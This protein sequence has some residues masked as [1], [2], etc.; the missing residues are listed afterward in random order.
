MLPTRRQFGTATAAAFALGSPGMLSAAASAPLYFD[1]HIDT[2]S[3]MVS[4][5]LNLAE[6]YP[7]T[8][9]DI[10]KMKQGGLNAGFF[11]V[12]A[13]ARN[14]TPL[15]SVKQGLRIIDVIVE[16]VK[17]HPKDLLLAT[18]SN[19]V[20]RSRREGKI[21]ILLGVEGGHMIDSS[22]EVL[23][24]FYRLG[25]RYLGLT[26][27]GNTPWVGAAEYPAEGPKGLNDFGREVV[28]EM[29]RLGMMV[30]MAHA[31]DQA[32][33][34]AVE[35]S[36]APILN[37][38]AACRA[39]SKHARNLTDDMLKALARNGGVL[40]VAYYSGMLD[41]GHAARFGELAHIARQ[42]GEVRKQFAGGGEKKRLSE[43]LWKLNLAEVKMIG[44]VPI[45]RF[46]DH[47]EHAAKVAGID[48]VGIGS[49]YDSIGLKLPEGL[50]HIGKTPAL[51]TA[52]KARGFSDVAV[53]KVM[54]GNMLRAM[55][56]AEAVAAKG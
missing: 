49:D 16:E 40:G 14:I 19:D 29:N 42:R 38:H 20:L 41:A 26:H 45:S 15:E 27:S 24:Q 10:P 8:C 43:E 1:L 9:V 53:A 4:E 44:Q 23:R 52:L 13:P 50:E 56:K 37:T 6:S 18:S 11:A 39:V 33:Y 46:V 30:D 3:R 22:L 5:G 28:R 36:K 7:Y 55:Q 47:V 35:T 2:P 31:S 32:F 51:I 12:F 48:H 17:R 54:G 25:V 21:G 34:D